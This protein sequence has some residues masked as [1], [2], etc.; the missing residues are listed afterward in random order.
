MDI[1][2]LLKKEGRPLMPA[3]AAKILKKTS[4]GV[5]SRLCRLAKEGAVVRLP[6]GYILAAA[7]GEDPALSWL[8]SDTP[9]QRPAKAPIYDGN[10][11]G[12]GRRRCPGNGLGNGQA[13]YSGNGE[14][15]DVRAKAAR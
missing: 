10:V 13:M 12:N 7:A 4:A 6:E 2:T 11:L 9:R 14:A 8:D 1:L 3:E 15:T 5:R